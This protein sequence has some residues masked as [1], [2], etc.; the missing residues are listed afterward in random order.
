MYVY[1]YTTYIH[2][3][4]CNMY[5]YNV[6]YPNSIP[7]QPLSLFKTLLRIRGSKPKS[8]IE[9]RQPS[10]FISHGHTCGGTSSGKWIY[11]HSC[12]GYIYPNFWGLE[13]NGSTPKNTP[14]CNCKYGSSSGNE[15]VDST[16][17]DGVWPGAAIR[18]SRIKEKHNFCRFILA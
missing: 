2:I 18:T 3:H 15:L 9:T 7:C 14:N 4:R 1:I 16:C 6:Q 11:N 13:S 10:D 5:I 17:F 12:R 8:R